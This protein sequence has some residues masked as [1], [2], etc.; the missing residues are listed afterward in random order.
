ML[1]PCVAHLGHFFL[2]WPT[3]AQLLMLVPRVAH[4]GAVEGSNEEKVAQG[5]WRGQP[6]KAAPF[7]PDLPLFIFYSGFPDHCVQSERHLCNP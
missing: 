5:I 7:H 4:L 1:V 6:R 2:A 3:W